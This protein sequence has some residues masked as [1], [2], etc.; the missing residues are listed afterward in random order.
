MTPLQRLEALDQQL[1]AL[2]QGKPELA[3]ETEPAAMRQRFW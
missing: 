2:E 3:G 1:I